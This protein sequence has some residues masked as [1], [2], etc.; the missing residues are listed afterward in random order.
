[1][2]RKGAWLAL[3]GGLSCL[4]MV[5]AQGCTGGGA[6]KQKVARL[7]A[8]V[9]EIES[10][11]EKVGLKPS[12]KPVKV[13]VANS[14]ILGDKNATVSVVAIVDMECPFCGRVNPMLKQLVED[15]QLKGKVNVVLKHFPLSFHKGA[16]PAAKAFIAV[17]EQN[18]DLAW[19]FLDKIYA[20]Q[21][22]LRVEESKLKE[23]A[24]TAK[25]DEAIAKNMQKV[26]NI[27][28][29]ENLFKNWVKQLGGDTEAFVKA[30]KDNDK[31]Y[32]DV[33]QRDMQLSIKEVKLEGTP[34]LLVGKREG[35]TITAWKLQGVSVDAVKDMI[36]K[37]SLLKLP[38]A[39][40]KDGKNKE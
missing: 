31:K 13:P 12:S 11:L 2:K 36:Q 9:A 35:D 33:I 16:T 14:P 34:T 26:R 40:K 17:G 30:L 29:R 7:E 28:L 18:L 22:Q 8:R 25:L 23:F 15:P 6:D 20:N 21:K 5:F 24:K 4:G 38:A 1:M 3:L 10:I 39:G 32:H 27:Y 37:K 19:K